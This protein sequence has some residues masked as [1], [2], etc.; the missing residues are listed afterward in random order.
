MNT[1]RSTWILTGFNS[2][3]SAPS[4]SPGSKLSKGGLKTKSSFTVP[5]APNLVVSFTSSRPRWYQMPSWK[6]QL[7]LEVPH[8]RLSA[9]DG[10]R[11]FSV[12][13]SA[14]DANASAAITAS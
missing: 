4:S 6:L 10:A 13:A 12:L 11:S 1:W 7:A 2:R 14:L 8:S 5:L 9:C 3:M